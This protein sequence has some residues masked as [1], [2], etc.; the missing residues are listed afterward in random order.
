MIKVYSNLS[1]EQNKCLIE[2]ENKYKIKLFKKKNDCVVL[3]DNFMII[4][5]C[6]RMKRKKLLD[7][8][9][10]LKELASHSHVDINKFMLMQN[11]I[12]NELIDIDN[13]IN[14]INYNINNERFIEIYEN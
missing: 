14:M 11:N 5:E 10:D 6:N 3:R 2:L 8:A 4:D 12:K 13:I 7:C 1:E 9:H